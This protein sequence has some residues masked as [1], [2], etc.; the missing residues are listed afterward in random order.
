MCPAAT[1]WGSAKQGGSHASSNVSTLTSCHRKTHQSLQPPLVIPMKSGF[2]QGKLLNKERRPAE[3]TKDGKVKIP[4]GPAN[5]G[6]S[7]TASSHTKGAQQTFC[8]MPPLDRLRPDDPD[9]QC[10][11]DVEVRDKIVKIPGFPQPLPTDRPRCKIDVLKGVG[12]ALVATKDIDVGDLIIAERPL[13]LI[14]GSMPLSKTLPKDYPLMLL[15]ERLTPED[16]EDFFALRN[17]KGYGRGEIQ[18][19]H[20]TNALGIQSLPAEDAHAG[21][22]CKVISRARHR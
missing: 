14:H 15:L 20:D 3:V 2:L 4:T 18:G 21:A 9:T 6:I 16:R 19:I 22:V 17:C 5:N 7:L 13:T 8:T 12:L 11:L 10:M 1:W